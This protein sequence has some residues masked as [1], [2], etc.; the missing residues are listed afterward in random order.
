LP[1]RTRPHRSSSRRLLRPRR[2]STRKAAAAADEREHLSV[3]QLIAQR[4]RD[5]HARAPELPGDLGRWSPRAPELDRP[6]MDACRAGRAGEQL[7][8]LAHKLAH[9]NK[10]PCKSAHSRRSRKPLSVVRRIEGSNPSPPL[11]KR[12]PATVHSQGLGA[13]RFEAQTLPT[14][15]RVAISIGALSATSTTR[16]YD[17]SSHATPSAPCP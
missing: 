3:R 2:P 16:R 12:V 1:F 4:V 5:P 14:R 9:E 8:W 11:L 6:P 17:L 15:P 13:S 10:S 7:C